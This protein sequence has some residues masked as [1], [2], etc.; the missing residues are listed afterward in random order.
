MDDRRWHCRFDGQCGEYAKR[1]DNRSVGIHMESGWTDRVNERLERIEGILTR[2]AA[3]RTVRDWYSTD[4]VAHI[5]GKAKFTVREWCRHGRIHCRK[6][7]NGRGRSQSWTISH[8][9][10]VRIQREGL[11]PLGTVSTTIK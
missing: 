9:E 6:K 8:E 7:L 1:A 2:M 4:E 5:L 3:D 11:L 10:L